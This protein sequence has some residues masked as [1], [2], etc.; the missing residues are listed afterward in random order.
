MCSCELSIAARCMRPNGWL[1]CFAPMKHTKPIH[2]SKCDCCIQDGR[3]VGRERRDGRRTYVHQR[4]RTQWIGPRRAP[5]HGTAISPAPLIQFHLC[6]VFTYHQENKLPEH[7][8]ELSETF[9]TRT[10]VCTYGENNY[11]DLAAQI[12]SPATNELDQHSKHQS[13]QVSPHSCNSPLHNDLTA[14]TTKGIDTPR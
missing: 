8:R 11:Q 12:P 9:L 4:R 2:T 6:G 13:L 10:Y 14:V 3:V 7:E 1:A 5:R